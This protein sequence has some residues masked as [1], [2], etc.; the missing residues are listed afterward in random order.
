VNYDIR[1]RIV[2]TAI[3]QHLQL[4]PEVTDTALGIM[5]WWLPQAGVEETIDVVEDVLNELVAERVLRKTVLPDGGILYGA[6]RPHGPSHT[7]D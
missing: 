2:R 1:K 7:A 5:Q 6:A 3:A 4:K